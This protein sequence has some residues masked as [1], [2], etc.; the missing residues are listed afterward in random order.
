MI[1]IY[2]DLADGEEESGA[3]RLRHHDSFW[4]NAGT[5]SVMDYWVFN[6]IVYKSIHDIVR[7]AIGSKTANI[8]Q[9]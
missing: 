5:N 4:V 6:D 3:G 9:L 1:R 8:V 7:A 2:R